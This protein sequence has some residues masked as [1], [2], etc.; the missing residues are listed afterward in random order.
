[1]SILLLLSV[2][3]GGAIVQNAVPLL[4][5]I[6]KDPTLSGRTDVWSLALDRAANRPLLGYGYRAYWIDGNKDRLQPYEGWSDHINHG[7]NTYLDLFVELGLLG[8]IAFVLVFFVLMF[9]IMR[10][11]RKTVDYL[12]LWAVSSI[13]F[14]IVRG[15]AESTVLQ[16][17]DIS[18]VLFVYFFCLFYNYGKQRNYRFLKIR[19]FGQ[20]MSLSRN[21]GTLGR[22][23][24]EL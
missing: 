21:E 17:A 15:S 19:G 9:R 14:I 5:L 7:H 10:R 16:H 8:L 4:E 20:R 18:W 11:I 12:N 24:G 23:G 6:G 2:I 3:I 22:A 13:S 1:M